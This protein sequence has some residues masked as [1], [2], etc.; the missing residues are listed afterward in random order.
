M[1]IRHNIALGKVCRV[2]TTIAPYMTECF[3]RDEEDIQRMKREIL[4]LRAMLI[5]KDTKLRDVSNVYQSL[6]ETQVS[7][8]LISDE[9]VVVDNPLFEDISDGEFSSIDLSNLS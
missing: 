2:A 9:I 8:D 1:S 6:L 3:K 5:A 4:Q 7:N